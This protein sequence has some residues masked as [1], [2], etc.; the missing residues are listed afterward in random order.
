MESDAMWKILIDRQKE[1]EA[2]RKTDSNERL[3]KAITQQM[4]GSQ[5]EIYEPGDSVLFKEN[6]KDRWSGPSK[7][8]SVEGSKVRV[9]HSRYERTVAKCRVQ[10]LEIK[11]YIDETEDN[12]SVELDG[13]ELKSYLQKIR[14]HVSS[15]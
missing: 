15:K 5:D 3:Q 11:R 8:T 12:E 14:D 4:Y 7:V 9:I 6:G 10:P 2:Y 13:E 1:E